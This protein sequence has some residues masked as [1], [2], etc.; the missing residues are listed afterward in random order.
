VLLATLILDIA[1]L[2]L[3]AGPPTI[4]FV[5]GLGRWVIGLTAGF[6]GM[7]RTRSLPRTVA[8]AS[9]GMVLGTLLT[10]T[11]Y[12]LTGRAAA[13]L[14]GPAATIVLL[15]AGTALALVAPTVGA[16]AA[17]AVARLRPRGA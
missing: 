5:T 14:F 1:T 16:L 8:A 6:V 17:L 9:G 10:D 2:M 15:L 12:I 7:R 13:D 4:P 3:Y 11:V